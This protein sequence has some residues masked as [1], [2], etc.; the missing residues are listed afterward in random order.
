MC[1]VLVFS[2]AFLYQSSSQPSPSDIINMGPMECT[3]NS[4]SFSFKFFVVLQCHA[5]LY[6]KHL[7]NFISLFEITMGNVST[8]MPS[9]GL[10]RLILPCNSIDNCIVAILGNFRCWLPITHGIIYAFVGPVILVFVVSIH[11]VI[12]YI[13]YMVS[14]KKV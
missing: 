12:Q 1:C 4:F 6:R 3:Y 13:L 7:L 10:V 14:Q 9:I 11:F 2:Q 5:M 8:N